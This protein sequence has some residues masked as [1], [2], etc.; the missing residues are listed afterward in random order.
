MSRAYK[1]VANPGLRKD[2]MFRRLKYALISLFSILAALGSG[3]SRA[4]DGDTTK[5][6]ETNMSDTALMDIPFETI[7]GDTTS[8]AAY[9]GRVILIVNVASKCGFTPQYEGLEKLYE[10]YRDSGLTVIGFPANNFGGQEPGSNEEILEF[11]T[12]NFGVTF[13][14]M[15]KVSVKGKDKHPLFVRLTEDPSIPGEIKW[16]FAKFLIDREGKLVARFGTR[17][18]PESKKLVAAIEELL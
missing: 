11:C 8:L 7:Q 2:E 15:A 4:S 9:K 6:R 10:Q 13:P 16:N 1:M 17:T 12:T 5:T 18:K 3:F 14:M